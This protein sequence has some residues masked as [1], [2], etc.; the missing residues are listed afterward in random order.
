[1]DALVGV[2]LE[3]CRGERR[4]DDFGHPHIGDAKLRRLAVGIDPIE[5]LLG[6]SG[7]R[8][9]GTLLHRRGARRSA[10][11]KAFLHRPPSRG[12]WS[13]SQAAL[14][15]RGASPLRRWARI[16]SVMW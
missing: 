14:P 13:S 15:P 10:W 5:G 7:L 6:S 16:C 8:H 4:A 1:D 3:E 11:A 9:D 12:L 2:D